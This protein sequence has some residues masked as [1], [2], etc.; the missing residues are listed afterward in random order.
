MLFVRTTNFDRFTGTSDSSAFSP[1][2]CSPADSV[3]GDSTFGMLS[4][5]MP[6]IG[7]KAIVVANGIDRQF[8]PENDAAAQLSTLGLRP[9]GYFFWIGSPSPRKNPELLLDSFASYHNRIPGKRLVIVAP[10]NSHSRLLEL[11]RG[12]GLESSL[13]LLSSVDDLTR[14]ALYRCAVALVFPSHCEGFWFSNWK[15][16]RKDVQPWPTLR[17]PLG[18]SLAIRCP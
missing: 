12:R 11:S 1:D 6:G 15:H 7:K 13:H 2:A 8:L 17:V 3:A 5:A 9:G 4:A 18:R 10:A 16:A 14:D